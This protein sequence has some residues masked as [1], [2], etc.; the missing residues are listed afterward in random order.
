MGSAAEIIQR[1]RDWKVFGT[2]TFSQVPSRR[3][4]IEILFAFLRT[5]AHEQKIPWPR[6]NWVARVELGE[7][8]CRR[9]YH[10]LIGARGWEP[11][12]GCLFWMN[13]LWD[14]YRGCGFSRNKRFDARVYNGYLTKLSNGMEM[15]E[16][17]SRY[18]ERKF[19]SSCV[20]TMV[21]NSLLH[22]I[23]EQ[24]VGVETCA[25]DTV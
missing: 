18:E 14:S 23:G 15:S 16:G 9:H 11:D 25:F 20:D 19:K 17:G 8:G 3:R 5:I 12:L 21:S 4:R 7:I 2:G 10:W 13:S 6:F 1:Y 22:L 24:R